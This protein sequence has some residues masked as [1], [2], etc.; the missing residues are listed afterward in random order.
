MSQWIERAVAQ[1]DESYEKEILLKQANLETLQSQINPHFLYNTL[2]CI[3]GMA[4]MEDKENI[5][6][7]VWSLSQFFRYSIS[8]KSN[9]VTLKDEVESCRAYA[10][11]QNYRF[12]DRFTLEI[13]G[14]RDVLG[15]M[16]P[17]L[18]LQPIVENAI[19]HGLKDTITGGV[20]TINIE[21]VGG[22][23]CVT[24][25][26]N[27]CG[28]SPDKLEEL[29]RTAQSGDA[30]GTGGHNGIAMYN[31]DRR[32]KLYFGREYGVTIYSCQG[33]GTDVVLRFPY[34][35]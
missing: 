1:R 17:K 33:V 32:I 3:R 10:N 28:I 13:T 26:D 7:I 34:N 20:I 9:I 15:A 21:R 27:G 11:I 8:G 31:V 2:E 23:L 19:L 16:V 12:Q 24:V 29:N 18:T 35:D 14:D 5:A 22:D 25:S 4:L 30:S 6:D